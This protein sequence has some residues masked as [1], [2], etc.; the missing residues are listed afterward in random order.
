[1]AHGSSVVAESLGVI[2]L[3]DLASTMASR[4]AEGDDV[5]PSPGD[6]IFGDEVPNHHRGN[7]DSRSDLQGIP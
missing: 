1:M 5:M 4:E 6:M 2:N 3:H 7:R